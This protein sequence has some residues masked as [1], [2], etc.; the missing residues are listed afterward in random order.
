MFE[1][2][3]IL[4]LITK[5][6]YTIVVLLICSI[7]SVAISIEKMMMFSKIKP[8]SKKEIDNIKSAVNAG[9]IKRAKEISE[10]SNTLICEVINEALKNTHGIAVKEAISRKISQ[11]I[12]KFE[13]HLSAVGTIGAIT[14]FIGLLGTVIGIMKAFHDLGKYGVGNPSIVSAGIAEALVATAA[15]LLVAIPSVML[16]NYFSKRINNLESEIENLTLEILSPVIY[17]DK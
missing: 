13:K 12:L 8:Y 16:Y 5:G 3:N 11:Q 15:G 2:L 4:Q 10:S 14:P 7:I 9:D 6:G 17:G 1:S